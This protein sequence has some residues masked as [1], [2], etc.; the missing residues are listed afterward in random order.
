M[1]A[2]PYGTNY[3][4]DFLVQGGQ[5]IYRIQVKAAVHLRKGL[6]CV[7]IYRH[8]G[9]KLRPYLASEIDFVAVYIIP[10]KTWYIVPVREVVDRR[11]LMFRPKGSDRRDPYGHY[12]EAWHLLS[13]PD[14]LVFG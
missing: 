11:M 1:V 6:Y 8:Q 5:N 13:E 9:R 10:E 7:N 12:R 4:F 3:P 14:G 2:Q